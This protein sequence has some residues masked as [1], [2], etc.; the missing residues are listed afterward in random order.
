MVLS[1][2]P[3]YYFIDDT[4]LLPSTNTETLLRSVKRKIADCEVFFVT[5]KS[6][7]YYEGVSMTPSD[8]L[9]IGRCYFFFCLFHNES[10][11]VGVQKETA[12]PPRQTQA[13]I[14]PQETSCVAALSRV[15]DKC[16]FSESM[17]Y[18]MCFVLLFM[19]FCR[20]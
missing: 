16:T 12:C 4:S 17:R 6:T 7:K 15:A 9:F 19:R 10:C 13:L 8:K 11:F 18:I 3:R 5:N 20:S 14:G 2:S 1:F